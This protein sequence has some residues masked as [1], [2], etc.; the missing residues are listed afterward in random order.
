MPSPWLT[1]D[2][3]QEDLERFKPVSGWFLELKVEDGEGHPQGE[4][5]VG[6]LV[7]STRSRHGGWQV[8]ASYLSASDDYY[9]WWMSEGDGKKFA[10]RRVYHLCGGAVAECGA[11]G[12]R[13]IHVHV[14]KS[15]R[16]LEEELTSRKVTWLRGEAKDTFEANVAKFY[17][18]L[19]KG[20]AKAPRGD[21]DPGA[22]QVGRRKEDSHGEGE[23]ESSSRSSSTSAEMKQRLKK[24]RADLAAAEK[25]R[26]DKKGKGGKQRKK[27]RRKAKKQKD[28]KRRKSERRSRGRGEKRKDEKKG[29]RR[30]KS[31]ASEAVKKKDKR[32]RSRGKKGKSSSSA[33]NPVKGEGV[34]LF[35]TS[36]RGSKQVAD[37]GD[38][39]PFGGGSAVDFDDSSSSEESSFRKGSSV[40]AKSSQMRL[41]RYAER[42]PGRLAS[43]LLL[44]MQEATA[45][46]A[47]EPSGETKSLT[48]AVAQNHLLTVLLPSL[49]E[50]AGVRTRRELKTLTKVLDSLVRGDPAG[51]ADVV[52]Q[53]VKA[54]ERASHEAHWG[55]AQYLELLPDRSEETFVTAQFLLDQKIKSYDQPD[56]RRPPKGGKDKEGKGKDGKNKKGKGPEDRKDDTKKA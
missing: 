15:R 56:R 34:P 5:L 35:R 41:V 19:R 14:G 42:H 45:R 32:K 24:L 1:G 38:R 33:S 2:A 40:S 17:G 10:T 23:D 50:K 31:P 6:V 43:R 8:L 47:L 9:R 21:G 53:R 25:E 49:G 54:L 55:T 30:S 4:V 16:V 51:A 28:V 39:G 11:K 29:K 22:V 48:P 3:L 18:A 13:H 44:K 52:A 26:E 37:G 20:A 46:G 27:E 12:A 7:E 36:G